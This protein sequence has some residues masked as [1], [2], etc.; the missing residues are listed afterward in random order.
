MLV[1]EENIKVNEILICLISL[2]PIEWKKSS[3]GKSVMF[4]YST[5]RRACQWR[6][7]L[8]WMEGEKKRVVDGHLT[9]F[10]L[11]SCSH[12]SS[13]LREW[14]CIH[15]DLTKATHMHAH[16]I[17]YDVTKHI[18]MSSPLS[19]Q[20][21]VWRRRKKTNVQ[22]EK[23]V[24]DFNCSNE[25]QKKWHFRIVR[26]SSSSS[27]ARTDIVIKDNIHSMVSHFDN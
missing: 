19:F 24:S 25:T 8:M 7:C 22:D 5:E 20:S 17:I 23:R 13:F 1:F 9:D 12:F 15:I 18:L 6:P 27:P 16:S 14:I 4:F 10:V 26:S 3:L 2:V 11:I 21:I